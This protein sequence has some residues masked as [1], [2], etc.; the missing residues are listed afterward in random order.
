MAI[1]LGWTAPA[2]TAAATD[3]Y[4]VVTRAYYVSRI[5]PFRP[6][7]NPRLS[8]AIRAF[9]TPS[10]VRLDGG[11][12]RVAWR[13]I[14]LRMT[15]ENFGGA[16]PGQTTCTPSVGRAQSFV[17]RGSRF[18]TVNGLRPGADS[19]SIP[20]RHPRA[21]F[22]PEGFWALVLAT[23]PFGDSEEPAPVLNALVSDGRVSALAGY[24]GGAGE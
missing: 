18:R 9:G 23:Y 13:R 17:A 10:R 24:I 1:A 5:G 15:F 6:A 12:C 3:S 2:P 8:A 19:S 22:Q 14:R 20:D 4:T 21:E 16:S 11:T 7:E